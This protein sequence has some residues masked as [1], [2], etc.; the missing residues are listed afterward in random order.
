M[1]HLIIFISAL[2][3]L[4]GMRDLGN[5]ELYCHSKNVHL[6]LLCVCVISY[7]STFILALEF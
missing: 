3:I 7:F 6:L 4:L 1:C 5:Y 2:N